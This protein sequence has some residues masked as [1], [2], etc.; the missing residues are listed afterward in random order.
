MASTLRSTISSGSSVAT[1]MLC[2]ASS[3]HHPQSSLTWLWSVGI[4]R[5]GIVISGK[6]RSNRLFC[7]RYVAHVSEQ[8]STLPQANLAS[9]YSSSTLS[10][11]AIQQCS[12]RNPLTSINSNILSSRSWVLSASLDIAHSWSAYLSASFRICSVVIFSSFLP[13]RTIG[14]VGFLVVLKCRD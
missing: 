1:D 12:H 3:L 6:S 13:A 11:S 2:I 8:G 9:W 7:A 5:S 10:F 4:K 14:V